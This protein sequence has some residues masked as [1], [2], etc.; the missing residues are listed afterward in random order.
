MTKFNTTTASK[1]TIN[2]LIAEHVR[3]GEEMQEIIDMMDSAD[4]WTDADWEAHNA[5]SK[6]IS[7]GVDAEESLKQFKRM[8]FAE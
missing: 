6:A 3:I 7:L 4:D 2:Y 8:R 5:L 1:H